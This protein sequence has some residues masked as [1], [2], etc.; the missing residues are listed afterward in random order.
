MPSVSAGFDI[1][2]SSANSWLL[3]LVDRQI[4]TLDDLDRF[5][6][7]ILDSHHWGVWKPDWCLITS[8][9]TADRCTLIAS[10]SANT[11]VAVNLSGTFDPA[12]PVEM[13]LTAGASIA[14]A[15]QQLIQSIVSQP[16]SIACSGLRVRDHS[17][18]DPSVGVLAKRGLF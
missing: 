10:N 11:N 1:A 9:A 13:K 7:A 4:R 18:S 6:R 15:N 17:W 16:S 2:F 3:A 12:A 14:A 5:R 8:L